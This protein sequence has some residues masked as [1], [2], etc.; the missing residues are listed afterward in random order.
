M[1]RKKEDRPDPRVDLVLDYVKTGDDAV[2]FFMENE[3]RNRVKV[4]YCNRAKTG[5]AYQPY[6]MVVVPRAEVESEHF[7][8]SFD[9]VVHIETRAGTSCTT[10]C[11]KLV[12]ML[13]VIRALFC[14]GHFQLMLVFLVP[15]TLVCV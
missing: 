3:G 8:F 15:S 11:K 12:L 9:G 6:D 10:L 1:K 2:R 13:P 4:F 5:K 7:S 14:G